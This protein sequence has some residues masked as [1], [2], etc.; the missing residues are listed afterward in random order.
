MSLPTYILVFGLLITMDN[1]HCPVIPTD[2]P[3]TLRSQLI[4]RR[5]GIRH[6]SQSGG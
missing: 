3:E 2:D 1:P 5:V 6:A 4:K